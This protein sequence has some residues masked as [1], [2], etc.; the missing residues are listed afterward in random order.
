MV[1]HQQVRFLDRTTPPHIGTLILLIGVPALSMNVFLPSLPGM[2]AYFETEYS[3]MQLSVSLYLAV[4]AVLQ[5]LVGPIADRMGRRPVI[6]WGF[7]GFLLATLGCLLAPTAEIFLTFRMA[8]AVIV[9]GMVLSRAVVRD[10]VPQDEAASMIGWIT[11]GMALVPMAAPVLGGL[12]DQVFGWK[13]NFLIQLLLGAAVLGL[14]WADLGE[15]AHRTSASFAQQI[16]EYPELLGSRRFWGYALAAAFAS[17]AFFA[18]LG[19]APY[20]GSE[21]FGLT[22]AML[23]IYFGA[24]AV[25]YG[26]GNGLSGHYS[27]RFGINTMILAGAWL[28]LAGLL[29]SVLLFALGFESPLVFFGFMT[30]VGIGNGL[31]LPNATSGLLSVRPHLAGTAS[32]LGGAVMI[33]GGA[34]LS[35]TAGSLLTPERGA[36]P[37]LWLMVGTSALALLC[38]IYVKRRERQIGAV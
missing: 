31:I 18:Y 36:W 32:G 7:G 26:I 19:G 27:A 38:I 30:F 8:Q 6:L 4:S 29:V 17:G 37:L 34:A 13:A 16:R 20:V 28:T 2:T 25:G 14:A 23:G 22:P 5:L 9:V 11:M 35:A 1:H 10:M 24:P 33:G 21:I 3:V 15:T 12:L